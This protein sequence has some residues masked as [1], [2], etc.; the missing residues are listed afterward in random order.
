[1]KISSKPSAQMSCCLAKLQIKQASTGLAMQESKFLDKN[2][3][4]LKIKIVLFE[5]VLK[6]GLQAPTLFV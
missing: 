2:Q 4:K 5:N 3:G 1:M 6:I